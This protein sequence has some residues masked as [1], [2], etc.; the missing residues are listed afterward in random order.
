M[1]KHDGKSEATNPNA[2][3]IEVLQQMA[4]HYERQH[5]HWRLIAYRKAIGALRR[6]PTKIITAKQA[7]AIPS[8]GARLADKIE[9]IVWT[10]SKSPLEP[11][12]LFTI[13]SLHSA[14]YPHE[15]SRRPESHSVVSNCWI[16]D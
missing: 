16:P 1:T 7:F 2:R 9:E 12:L 13:V 15:S 14:N 6:Q 5:D 10:N 11:I 4:N 3:T 8:I